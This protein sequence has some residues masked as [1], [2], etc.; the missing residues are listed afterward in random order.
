MVEKHLRK[1]KELTD[2][3]A[4]IGLPL[5]EEDQVITLLGSLTG[6]W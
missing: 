5:A 6:H 3:L 4:A 1:M 2:R